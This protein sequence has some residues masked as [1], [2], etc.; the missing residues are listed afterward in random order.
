MKSKLH[1]VLLMIF[2]FSVWAT[3]AMADSMTFDQTVW[4]TGK[5]DEQ[6]VSD[7]NGTATVCNV[8]YYYYYARM[9][10]RLAILA[11]SLADGSSG[12]TYDSAVLLLVVGST[13]L[14]GSDEMRIFGRRLSRNWSENGASWTYYW[15]SIDSAWSSAG[16]DFNSDPCTDTVLIDTSIST[17]DTLSFYLDTG[18]VRVMI[19]ST[20]NG[21]LMMAENIVDRVVFGFYTE[22]ESNEDFKP[23]LTIYYTDGGPVSAPFLRRR[24]IT[25]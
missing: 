15:A 24:R 19:E 18:F 5:M 22:D 3:T 9:P 16:G 14:S 7:S 6:F 23:R 2:L 20:N 13:S 10:L 25:N 8:D 12:R 21:W 11:D 17:D 1:P 4:E